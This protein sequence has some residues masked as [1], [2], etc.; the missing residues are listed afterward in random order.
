M[1]GF[2]KY[3]VYAV[4]VTIAISIFSTFVLMWRNSIK[5]QALLEANN[6][7]LNQIVEDQQR[8]IIQMDAVNGLQ[9]QTIELLNKKND[10][11]KQDMDTVK[12]FLESKEAEK[13]DQPASE[14]VKDVIRRLGNSK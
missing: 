11:L 1:F 7:Q 4:I 13:K 9:Q 10:D 3:I 6:R 14:I 8:F 12:R 5:Q 2:N